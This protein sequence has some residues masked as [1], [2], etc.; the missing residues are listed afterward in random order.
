MSEYG[1]K[2][3]NIKAG[4]L[5]GYNQGVR[6]RYD[7]T[8]AMFSNSLFSDYIKS[9]GMNVWKNES[10]RDIIC[11]D[12]DFG[13]RT[14]D[15]EIKHLE[16]RFGD[17]EN[18]MELDEESKKKIRY[19]FENVESNKD[20]YEKMSKDEIREHFYTNGVSVKY[21]QKKKDG[22][23]KEQTIHYKMLYRNSSKAKVGQ[24]MFINSKL[25]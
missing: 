4:T 18:N 24:V 6:D 17:F 16:E 13:S 10:T 1:L 25:F 21:V 20:K 22:D 3:K 8:D 9:N 19:I 11:L 15:E 5:F 12:F 14:Y 7:F 2:I 23:I